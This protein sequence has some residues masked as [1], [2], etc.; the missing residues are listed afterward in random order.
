MTTFAKR[1]NELRTENKLS[2]K[3]LAQKINVTDGAISNWENDINEP[4]ISYLIKLAKFFG[5]SSDYL[6]GLDN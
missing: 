6:L 1:L 2:M 5:V 4:K 3:Q